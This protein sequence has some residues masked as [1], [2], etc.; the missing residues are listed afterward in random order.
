MP[1]V[2]KQQSLS[3]R[4]TITQTAARL[5]REHGIQ[6]ISV[7]D[8]MAAAGL[9]HGGFYGHFASKDA[10][11][12]E[13]CS[14]AFE[15]SAQRWRQRLA[16]IA[17]PD[18]AKALLV[19]GYLSS[20]SRD[21]PGISCPASSLAGDVAREGSGAAVRAEF[22]SGIEALVEILGSLQHTGNPAGDRH[23]A[24]ADLATMVGAQLLARAT[25]G[26]KVS[27]EFLRAARTRLGSPRKRRRAPARHVE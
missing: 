24:L 21:D 3:N 15:N 26:R 6:G 11:A 25:G 9:T 13:A 10:L 1:R 7:A 12:A 20:K 8:L 14:L 4:A 23:E 2:S 19:Q 18:A 17:A 16:G 27:D 5:F 22:A